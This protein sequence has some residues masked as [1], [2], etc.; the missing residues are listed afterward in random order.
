ME[1]LVNETVNLPFNLV[2]NFFQLSRLIRKKN[3]RLIFLKEGPSFLLGRSPS[4]ES[5][6]FHTSPWSQ[7]FP[8]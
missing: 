7:P 5:S 6:I 1:H 8:E 4:D 2:S 3:E